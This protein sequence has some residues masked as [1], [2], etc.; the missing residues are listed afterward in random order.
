[1]HL[2]RVG[3]FA[4][5]LGLALIGCGGSKPTTDGGTGG[6]GGGGCFDSVD[7]PDPN[8][9]YCNTT[10]SE[11]VPA[12]RTSEDC[13]DSVRGQ[14]KLDYCSGGLGCQCDDG[15]CVGSV[16]GSDSD[17]GTQVCR[18]GQCVDAPAA[19][20]VTRCSVLPDYAVLK[21][22]TTQKFSVEAFDTA[23]NPVVLN[24]GVTWAA[25]AVGGS[26]AGTGNSVVYTAP[27]A[28][29][30][31]GVGPTATI[32]TVSCSAKIVSLDG[33]V[34]ASEIAVVVTDEL[35]GRGISGATVLAS[36][37]AGAAI[38]A[39]A[40]TNASGYAKLTG[41]TGTEV[42]V[43]V[44][45]T[46]YNYLTIANYDV[47]GG[48][49]FLSAVLRRHQTDKY[50]GQKGTFNNVPSSSNVH[51]GLAGMSIA[52]SVVDLSFQQLLGNTIPTRVKIGN[53]IDQMNVPLPAGVYLGF[54]SENIKTDISAQGL[55]GVCA[56]DAKTRAG[57][58]GTR[59][60]W[61]L[62]GDVPIGDLPIDAFA[63]G[64]SMIDYASVLSRIIPIFKKFN[65]SVI[66]D[67]EF[68]LK[69]TPRTNGVPD[70][71]STAEFTA[72]NHEFSV[73]ADGTG[74]VPLAFNFVNR[75]PDLPKFRNNYVD[76]LVMLGGAN[77][78]GRGVVPLGLGVA[79][80]DNG[81]AKIDKSMDLSAPGLV[82]LRMAPT[83]HGIEGTEYGVLAL[84][85]PFKAFTDVS[86]GISISGLFAHPAGNKLAFDPT[87]ASAD[88]I[89]DF[90]AGGTTFPML[91]EGAKYNYSAAAS[92]GLS[93]RT[94]RIPTFTTTANATTAVRVSFADNFDHR[95]VVLAD[96]AK[97]AAGVTLPVPPSGTVDRTFAN[98]NAASGRSTLLVQTV[99][100]SETPAAAS[101]P[102]LT[103]RAL[104]EANGTNAD[105]MTDFTTGF[106][107]IDYGAPSIGWKTPM[108]NGTITH[109]MS[110]TVTVNHFKVG[111]TDDGYV[112][113]TFTGG[114]GCTDAT[115]MADT[116]M[117]KGEIPVVIP[118]GCTGTGIT[119]K[120][121]LVDINGADLSPA[122]SSTITITV[123]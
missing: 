84:G 112:K 59:T 78:P 115:G 14:Y 40:M 95:W 25:G 119:A 111:A 48:S 50:G 32:G 118:A 13:K 35:T 3:F 86:A 94:F 121:S 69:D 28:A 29:A 30:A 2:V 31:E 26:V 80:N 38:G 62:S 10:I 101:P 53:A 45:S 22:G 114:T 33:T 9:F 47:A 79:V 103:Y 93:P 122:V 4:G 89:L 68:S 107:F 96:P 70:F 44:F 54:S 55:A 100:L 12:C 105:R 24:A 106:A 67:V 109:G 27:S 72:K 63:G 43:S 19:T 56:D 77:V 74:A 58:C 52:G 98:G 82:Q 113:V 83:H 17:C 120:A 85:L 71:S 110:A 61:A 15:A 117:G 57:T 102:L 1:M 73:K 36:D 11:C 91:P 49:R 108:N 87:G 5:L 16:C 104:V 34:A 60:G 116:S 41:V 42:N 6:G 75:I 81:D 88:K 64:V 8:L 92:G 20:T 37:T 21:A 65:S 39:T 23:G 66:R 97:V 46:S 90:G 7:C 51:A 76:G 123:N 18:N 99:R